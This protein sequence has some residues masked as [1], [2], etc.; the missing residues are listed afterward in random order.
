L[1]FLNLKAS[2]QHTKKKSIEWRASPG[3]GRKFFLTIQL[4]VN[5]QNIKIKH[6]KAKWYNQ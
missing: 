1:F 3:Y 4:S 6:Q 2:A 5:T